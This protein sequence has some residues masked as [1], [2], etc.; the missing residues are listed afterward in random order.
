MAS[1]NLISDDGQMWVNAFTNTDE[2]PIVE[3]HKSG[4]GMVQ[5]TRAELQLALLAIETCET[6]R[7][8][9]MSNFRSSDD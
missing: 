4:F 8:T 7:L 6:V 1:S 5:L 2:P 9:M 3:I